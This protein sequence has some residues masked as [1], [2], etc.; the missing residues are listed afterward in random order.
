MLADIVSKNGNLLLNV[1]LYADGSLPPESRQFL[2]EMAAWMSVNGEAIY[3]T[4]PWKIFGEGPTVPRAGSFRENTAY[5]P[6]DIRFTTKDGNLYAISLGWP[7][8]GKVVI[9]SLAKTDDANVNQIQ[10]IELLG[11]S[12][13]LKFNQTANGL[14]VE[15]PAQKISDM[16]CTLKIAGSNLQPVKLAA[17]GAPQNSSL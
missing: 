17:P 1:L 7:A 9:H 5:T 10:K 4:R 11:G 16:A 12:G 8:D 6:R 2:D 15:L 14:T 3:D 13:E